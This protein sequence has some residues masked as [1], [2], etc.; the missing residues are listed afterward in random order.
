VKEL[1]NILSKSIKVK[2]LVHFFTLSLILLFAHGANA[3][4]FFD[5]DWDE[6]AAFTPIAASP[7]P[8]SFEDFGNHN[9]FAD[10]IIQTTG[11]IDLLVAATANLNPGMPMADVM[12]FDIAGIMLGQ[13]FA[14]V[15][16]TFRDTPQLYQ[17]RARNPVVFSI[18]RDWKVNLDYECRRNRVFAPMAL[19]NCINAIARER[20]LLYAAQLH[21][22]RPATGETITVHFTSNATGNV[23]WRV[24]YENDVDNIPGDAEIFH[25][26]R[27][28]RVFV[29]WNA[30]V[31]KF[32]MPNSGNDRWISSS[33]TFEPMMTVFYGRLD[34]TDLGLNAYDV[35][36]N[37]QSARDNFP[38][39]PYFF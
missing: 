11:D 27:E 4:P 18:S 5:F 2:S 12:S 14:T 30:V 21:L 29:W 31:E 24:I 34:L 13:D 28:S 38:A 7:A 26:Q 9:L 3:D 36:L 37:F 33:S 15:Y 39:L 17:F 19:S 35:S 20:G 23:V 10:E 16:R 6:P 8:I 1:K 25:W 22:E 32:G